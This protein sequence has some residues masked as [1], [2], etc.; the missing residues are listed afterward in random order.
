MVDIDLIVQTL[1]DHGHMVEDVHH[2][3]PD[4]GEYA[5][6]VDGNAVNL[7]GARQILESDE[8]K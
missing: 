8:A 7:E 1:R 2:V 3:S 4:A 5:L 6:T